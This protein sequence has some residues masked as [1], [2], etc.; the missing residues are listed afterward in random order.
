MMG[1]ELLFFRSKRYKV[2]KVRYIAKVGRP[3]RFSRNDE[4]K[5]KK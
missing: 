4:K 2:L 1:I 5:V 3:N